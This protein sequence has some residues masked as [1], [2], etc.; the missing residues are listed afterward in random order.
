MKYKKYYILLCLFL[1]VVTVS[2]REDLDFTGTGEIPRIEG[3]PVEISVDISG[4]FTRGLLEDSKKAFETGEL[5]HIRAEYTC[6]DE[7]NKG[8]TYKRVQYGVM[9]YAGRGVWEPL[10]TAELLAWPATALHADFTACYLNG[11]TG[12]LT[13]QTMNPKL[14]SDYAYDEDPLWGETMHVDYGH[15]VKFN[16]T[17][18]FTHLQ[19][20]QINPGIAS[21]FYFTLPSDSEDYKDFNNAFQ[22]E[23][24]EETKEMTRV[25]TKVPS[26]SY[27]DSSGAGIVFVSSIAELYQDD[28]NEMRARVGYFLQ[29][30]TYHQFNLLYPR[31]REQTATYLNYLNDLTE[32]TGPAGMLANVPYEF[33]VLKSAGVFVDETPEDGWDDSDPIIIVDVEKFLKA[34]NSG[35]SYSQLN[36][37]GEEIEI[38]E[39]TVEGVRLLKN[40]DFNHYYY[41]IFQNGDFLPDLSQVFDGNYHYIYNMACPLFNENHGEIKNVGISDAVTNPDQPIQSNENFVASWGGR[42]RDMSRNGIIC[43]TNIGNI[44]NVRVNHVEMEVRIKTSGNTFEESSQEA[45]TA[46]ILIGSNRGNA[47]NI[48]CGGELRITVKNATEDEIMPNVIIGGI[49]GQNLGVLSGVNPI[50]DEDFATPS[51][52]II[53][54][55]NGSSGVYIVGG[56]VGNHTG[57]LY[58][59]TMSDINVNGKNSSGVESIM[60]GIVG[61]LA[62]SS[63]A[64][65]IDGC[66]VRGSVESGPSYPVINITSNSYTGGVAG[67]LNIQGIVLNSSASMAVYGTKIYDSGVTYAVGGAFGRIEQTGDPEGRINTL[68]CFGSA[69]DG[70]VN[71]GNFAGM[72]PGGITWDYYSGQNINVKQ[73]PQYNNIATDN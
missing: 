64:P 43:R 59:I 34:V 53:N 5:L 39:S 18:I 49:A 16:M 44:S 17:H 60:G 25:F 32:R 6:E 12:P 4:T 36:D 41:D 52:R 65:V 69:L 31:S 54:E 46:A 66:I 51:Y 63:S 2:C 26:N 48:S 47:Y 24:D 73:Y 42:A 14:L 61:R 27:K 20:T 10:P 33:S 38:L 7:D 37:K 19:I 68:A 55:C 3:R 29:P 23:F 50:D 8:V 9:K 15:A 13:G 72:V 28:D 57:S 67:S 58:D 71:I 22:L 40:I 11:S 62:Q 45:H 56:V 1:A 35:E 30:K 21:E 70:L